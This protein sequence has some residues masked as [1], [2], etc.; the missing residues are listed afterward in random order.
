[1]LKY[2]FQDKA[3]NKGNPKFIF[4]LAFFRLVH[5]F[6]KDKKSFLW[7]CGIPLMA[8]Y[9]IF[10]EDFLCIEIRAATKVGQGL[11]IEH[12][13]ALVINDSTIIGDNVHLRHSTTIGCKMKKDGSQGPSPVIGNN[14]EVGAHVVIL[15]G[16]YI[17]DNSKIAIGSIVIDDVPPNS[18]VAGNPAKV[19]R[20]RP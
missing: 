18:I 10:V 13:F 7:F 1:M 20:Q 16:I 12:G 19:I 3:R 17:G 6:A 9:R 4:I 11:K 14:V 15:G 2:L 5:L 8:T